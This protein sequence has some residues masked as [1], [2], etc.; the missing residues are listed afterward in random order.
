MQG[1]LFCRYD[2]EMVDDVVQA[3]TAALDLKLQHLPPH[4]VGLEDQIAEVWGQLSLPTS[5]VQPSQPGEPSNTPQASVRH[6]YLQ[7][8]AFSNCL[9]VQPVA[10]RPCR[11]QH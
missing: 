5:P 10:D 1:L 9:P 4:L 8:E 3:C 6:W 2:P 11:I 7:H